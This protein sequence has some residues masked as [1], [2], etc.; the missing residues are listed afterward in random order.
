[1]ADRTIKAVITGSS[2]GAVAAFEETALAA[3]SAGGAVGDKIEAAGGRVS[4]VFSKLGQVVGN[5]VPMLQE[6]FEKIGESFGD[7]ETK[8]QGLSSAMTSLG[9][10][11][12]VAGAAAFAG[13]AVEST[14]LAGAFQT[15][16]TS[17]ASNASIP[18][19]AAQAIG[20]AFLDTAGKSVFSGQEIGTAYAAVAGQL[21]AT[22]GH[23]LDAAQALT[24]MK[25][26]SDLAEASGTSLS[27]AT[28]SL[29]NVMQAFK[30]PTTDAASA[31][32]TLYN[33]SKLTG[34]GVDSLSTTFDKIHSK[35]GDLSPSLSG[36]SALMVDMTNQGITGKAAV[37]A[38]SSAFTGLADPTAKV[39]AAQQAMGVSFINAKTGALDPM[40]QIISEL[41]PKIDSLGNAQATAALKSLG[42]GS[43]SAALVS[44]IKAGTPAFDKASDS[45]NK[46]GTAADAAGLKSQTLHNQMETLK[47]TV[48]DLATKFG[49]ALIPILEKVGSALSD[50]IGWLLKHQAAMIA[51]AAVIGGVVVT[52]IGMF[53]A[54]LF[55]AEGAL[56]FIVGPIGLVIAAV[57]ALAAAAYLI[58]NNWGTISSF[59]IGLWNTVYDTVFGPMVDFFTHTIPDAVGDVVNWI[60]SHWELLLAIFLAPI[61]P[62]I[63][64]FV[65]FHDQIIGFV[66]GLV[67]GIVNFFTALP[68]RIVNGL[69]DIVT[70]VWSGL[71]TAATWVDTNVIEPVLGYFTALPG[72]V[73][74]GLGNIVDTIWGGLKTA[75]SWVD[76]NVI[77]PV[78]NF[79]TGLPDKIKTG[80]ATLLSIIE[81]PFSDAW[82]WIDTNVIQKLESWYGDLPSGLKSAFSTISDI[83]T[84]PFKAAFNGIANLW[85]ESVGSISFSL[86]SWIPGI[87]GDGFSMPRIPLLANGG[88]IPATPGGTLA[89]LGEGGNDEA[90][91]PLRGGSS[92]IG[93]GDYYDFSGMTVVANDPQTLVNQLKQFMQMNG[94]L[95]SAGIR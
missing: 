27:S 88:I 7:L 35:L 12:L 16:V 41:G 71:T 84:A 60:Q 26:S 54:S 92:G 37:S 55:T 34:Q 29:A 5:F 48:D 51:I 30:L 15:T 89:I 46:T 65:L 24:V 90:V 18:V 33:A 43:G 19:T 93:G 94:S 76:N 39:S 67:D 9:G 3:D 40:S 56:A 42:F 4:T 80:L 22:E 58:V 1:M 77:T 36:M 74:T 17:I 10:V 47:A 72:R 83:I 20:N 38:L 78:L 21:G 82:S 28:S 6:P 62:V 49:Q 69:G 87:G 8:G 23:A 85:N 91:I 13:V 2:A 79:F 11:A 31:S 57:A 25:A 64:A 73:V 45:V 68:G 52:A 32:D 75:S 66:S 61:A 53:V 44:V 70:T 95:A 81:E 14:K 50:V 86:P 63:A 59:F